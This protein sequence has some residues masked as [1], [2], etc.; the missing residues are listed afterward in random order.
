M[1]TQQVIHY[2]N[3]RLGEGWPDA[4]I[5]KAL[6]DAGWNE[7]DIQ[8]VMDHAGSI[9]KEPEPQ[10]AVEES[11]KGTEGRKKEEKKKSVL[12]EE[13]AGSMKRTPVIA[14]RGKVKPAPPIYTPEQIS[15][16]QKAWVAKNQIIE[17]PPEPEPEK[18][19]EKPFGLVPGDPPESVVPFLVTVVILLG[20]LAGYVNRSRVLPAVLPVLASNE[21]VAVYFR[22]SNIR[23]IRKA[24]VEYNLDNLTYPQTLFELERDGYLKSVPIDPFTHTQYVYSVSTDMHNFMLCMEVPPP[25]GVA[26]TTEEIPVEEMLNKN[27]GAPDI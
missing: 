7:D 13:V 20:L 21:S 3:A 27:A 6:G 4:D 22:T 5:R 25:Q 1:V 12:S 18:P 24:L 14:R 10:P 17:P 16:A 26:C 23:E 9:P 11:K 19:S 2:V 8:E 15:A